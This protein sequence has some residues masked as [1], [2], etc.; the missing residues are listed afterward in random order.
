M[1]A[2]FLA[3]TD[4]CEPDGT[5]QQVIFVDKSDD[6][7]KDMYTEISVGDVDRKWQITQAGTYTITLNQLLDQVTITK[8]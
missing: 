5:V 2:W 7:Y 6:T 3:P 1:G 4:G 8:N